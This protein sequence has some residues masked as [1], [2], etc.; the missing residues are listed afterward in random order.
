MGA[1]TCPALDRFDAEFFRIAPVEAE[2]M[3]PQQRLL[4]EVVWEAL[5][6]AGVDPRSLAGS[7]TGVYA[8]IMTNDYRDVAAPPAGDALRGLHF[9]TG[10]SAATA[11]GRVAFTLGLEGPAIAVDTACSSSLVA[12]HQAAA[13]LARGETD[14]ALAG[15]VNAILS[16]G[17]TGLFAEA[18]MLAPDGRCKTFDAAANGFVRGE[19]C[20]IVALK[21]LADAERDGDR[22]LAVLLGSAVNQDGASAGLTVPNGPAQERVIREALGRAGGGAG[23]GGLPGGARDGHG[24]RGPDRGRGGRGGV[25]RGPA[26]GP[27]AAAGLGE[28]ERGS[29]GGGGGGSR[30]W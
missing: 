24:T 4:L 25:W 27:A 2:L 18:G 12:I 17:L 10:N 1:R 7:R 3:D 30:G 8:G 21:R 11:I 29:P 23:D 20:G 19:G 28:D 5:E 26:R 13:G 15:G 22:I 9:A 6:D 16:A 14:L